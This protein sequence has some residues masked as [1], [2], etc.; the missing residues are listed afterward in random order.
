MPH[1]RFPTGRTDILPHSDQSYDKRIWPRART[2]TRPAKGT[3]KLHWI[4]SGSP[5]FG[6]A[7]FIVSSSCFYMA[8]LEA[9]DSHAFPCTSRSP[10]RLKREL[11]TN[12]FVVFLT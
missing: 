10:F 6:L 1:Q 8:E 2:S 4:N 3:D 5:L 9:R 11:E 12:K 7:A